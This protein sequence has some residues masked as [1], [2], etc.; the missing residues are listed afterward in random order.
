MGDVST[1]LLGHHVSILDTQNGE[2][3]GQHEVVAVYLSLGGVL[4]FT[5]TDADGA[6][7]THG[8]SRVRLIPSD[9]SEVDF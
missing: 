8:M 6:F 7:S 1:N 2:W 5:T 4:E 9:F 3:K